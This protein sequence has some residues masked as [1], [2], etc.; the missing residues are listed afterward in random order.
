MIGAKKKAVRLQIIEALGGR[1][2]WSDGCTMGENCGPQTDPDMLHIEH[3]NGGGNQE[4]KMFG[5]KREFNYIRN[6]ISGTGAAAPSPGYYKIILDRVTSGSTDYQLLC[7]NH[8][9]K[10]HAIDRCCNKKENR[11]KVPCP[12]AA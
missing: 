4:R 6:T 3:K 8:N 7:A 5:R 1:C 11:G 2:M 12:C 9:F 10:K